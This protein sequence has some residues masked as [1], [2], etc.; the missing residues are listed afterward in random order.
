[1]VLETPVKLSLG[2][3]FGVLAGTPDFSHMLSNACSNKIKNKP[4]RFMIS[5]IKEIVVL[6]AFVNPSICCYLCSSGLVLA[7]EL[8]TTESGY[9]TA[10][11]KDCYALMQLCNRCQSKFKGNKLT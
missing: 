3:Y 10:Q 1:V 7:E 2:C 6:E 9:K 8:G 5:K 4:L 11:L